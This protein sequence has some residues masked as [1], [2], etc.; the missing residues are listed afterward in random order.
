M[1]ISRAGK[2]NRPVRGGNRGVTLIEM[3]VV[4]TIIALIAG[5][6][7]P[8]VTAG[9][10]SVRLASSA[11][12]IAA[13]LNGAVN[14]AERRGEP[15]E[16]VI[17]RK[18]NLLAMYSNQPGFAREWKLPDGISIEALTPRTVEDSDEVRRLVLMPGSSVPGIG[19]QI[20]TRRGKHRLIR[21]DPMTGFPRVES[22][23][24]E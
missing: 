2:I 4:V 9:I 15:V 16:L 21:L 12:S 17:S 7:I 23:S 24:T 19:I 5:V 6:T 1:P 10:D 8:A 3:M 20:G 13:F 22:V 18:D 11:D 14:R